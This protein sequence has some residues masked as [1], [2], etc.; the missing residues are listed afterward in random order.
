MAD[1]WGENVY[2]VGIDWYYPTII[3]NV[4]YMGE[5]F[6]EKEES[7]VTARVY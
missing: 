2:Y 3:N 4:Y 1:V 6:S 7:M 5:L